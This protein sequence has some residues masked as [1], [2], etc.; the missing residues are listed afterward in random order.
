MMHPGLP[1]IIAIASVSSIGQS[2][3]SLVGSNHPEK[4][5]EFIVEW[6]KTQIGIF[7][8]RISYWIRGCNLLLKCVESVIDESVSHQREMRSLRFCARVQDPFESPGTEIRMGIPIW[9]T[10]STISEVRRPVV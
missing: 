5:A 2:G 10:L 4:I 7:A 9:A 8:D 6:M 3:H 1:G